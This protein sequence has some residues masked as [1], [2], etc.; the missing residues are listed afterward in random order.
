MAGAVEYT[1]TGDVE[2]AKR[3]AFDTL[4]AGGFS[5]TDLGNGA[6]RVERG[7]KTKTMWLGGLAGQDFHIAFGFEV[8]G[9]TLRFGQRI[10]GTAFK[11]GAVG[12][13]KADKAFAEADVALRNALGGAGLLGQV[14]AV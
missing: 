7:N 12:L 10:A 11:G 4:V 14:A 1:I 13:V 9:A 3:V 5:V 8:A 6:F 2:A